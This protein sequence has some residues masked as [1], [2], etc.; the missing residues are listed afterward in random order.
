[1]ADEADRR[2]YRF[3]RSK[4]NPGRYEAKLTVTSGQV[5]YEFGHLL[6]KLKSRIPERYGV[7]KESR[8]IMLHPLFCEVA[9]E[10]ES[11]EK[12]KEH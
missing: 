12:P 9:G 10:I 4:I 11:W 5:A 6:E 8:E 1:M 2:G 7:V 3:D